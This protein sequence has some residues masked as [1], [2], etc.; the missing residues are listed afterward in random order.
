MT[1]PPSR[2]LTAPNAT[3]I[4]TASIAL[5]GVFL[6]LGYVDRLQELRPGLSMQIEIGEFVDNWLC[7]YRTRTPTRVPSIFTLMMAGMTTD[8]DF[9]LNVLKYD[10]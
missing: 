10:F 1:N 4:S 9:R 5:A 7:R 6:G 2:R 3:A 8:F